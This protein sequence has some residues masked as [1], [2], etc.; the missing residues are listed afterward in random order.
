MI[1]RSHHSSVAASA[2]MAAGSKVRSRWR[3]A[4]L[5]PALI[6]TASPQEAAATTVRKECKAGHIRWANNNGEVGRLY[7]EISKF[8]DEEFKQSDAYDKKHKEYMDAVFKYGTGGWGYGAFA[9][10]KST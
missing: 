9:F 4:L 1:H 2:S 8:S 7:M 6:L 5:L 10:C 3:L